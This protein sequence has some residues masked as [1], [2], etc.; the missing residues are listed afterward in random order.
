MFK[1]WIADIGAINET[2][3]VLAVRAA[4]SSYKPHFSRAE[5]RIGD[6]GLRSLEYRCFPAW[7][8]VS[9]AAYL[10]KRVELN[11][12]FIVR[13]NQPSPRQSQRISNFSKFI[14][15]VKEFVSPFFLLSIFLF[16]AIHA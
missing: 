14:I 15:W 8:N 1:P 12:S 6:S 16:I 2:M 3:A 13:G 10:T 11:N 7:V 5:F 9:R 4:F